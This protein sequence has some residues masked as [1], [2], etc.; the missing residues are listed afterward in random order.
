[1]N[2]EKTVVVNV[3]FNSSAQYH[4]EVAHTDTVQNVKEKVSLKSGVDSKQ[5]QLIFAGKILCNET[6]LQ[7]LSLGSESILHAF[8]ERSSVVPTLD[9]SYTSTTE[10]ADSPK[11]A[12]PTTITRTPHQ[13]YVY[14]KE[15]NLLQV[16]KLR[17]RCK[18]CQE[19]GIILKREPENWEDVLNAERIH[20]ECKSGC[21][22]DQPAQFYFKCASH[23]GDTQEAIVVPLKHIRP[24]RKLVECITCGCVSTPI[25]VFPCEHQHVMC[26]ECFKSYG[27]VRL[28][29][30][31]FVQDQEYGYS[32]PCPAG[33]MNS[34]IQESHH[35]CLL[36]KN[37]YERYK[38]FGAEECLLQ[39]GGVQCPQPQCGEGMILDSSISKITCPNCRFKFCR[40]CLSEYHDGECHAVQ[41]M[42]SYPAIMSVDSERELRARWDAESAEFI[43]RSTKACPNCRTRTER[44][45]G[46]MHMQCSRCQE[47]WCWMCEKSWNRECQGNHWF[48]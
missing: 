4:L 23:Q 33:C 21:Y 7:D 48:G 13:Y 46:C 28:N 2:L 32:L 1:M 35:F 40:K 20:G 36:G 26:L 9:V 30:R 47:E 29:D 39:N 17:V 3:K 25:L 8:Q 43:Q 11:T 38:I 27:N 31:A 19:G 42:E 41:N 44:S 37:Q 14:C 10:E 22:G 16:G 34:L 18:R 5:I 15:C 6:Q 12:S 24:N 45:G